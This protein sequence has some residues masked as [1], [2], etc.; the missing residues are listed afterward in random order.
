MSKGK[1]LVIG[2]GPIVIGQAAEFDFSGSQ[3]CRSFARKAYTTVL[4]NSNPATIQTDLEMA[5]IVYIEPLNVE[6]VAE[7][8]R[9]E[10][11]EGVLSGM[12]GQTGSEP[13]LRACRRRVPGEAELPFTGNATSKPS[14][15]PRT[16]SCSGRP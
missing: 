16:E 11:T 10:K 7:I 1:L 5:D 4:V 9:K 14:L 13:V 15:C 2:S 3:A 12:G 8:I 6:T